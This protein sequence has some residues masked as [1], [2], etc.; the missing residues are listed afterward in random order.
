MKTSA[1]RLSAEL[2]LNKE[3]EQFFNAKRVELLE[4]I[5][6]Y[7]SISKAAKASK[8][9]YKTAWEWIEKMNSLSP[10]ALVQRISGGKGGGG[11]L[12]TAYAKELMRMYE[13]V[14][15]LHEK[16][17]LTLQGAFSQLEENIQ[18]ERFSFSRLNA[19]VKEISSDEKR[20]T[21]LLELMC[22]AEVS[23]QAPLTFVEVNALTAGSPIVL[24]I[25]SEAVSVSRSLPK[26]LSSRNK[27]K[28][29]VAEISMDGEDV[30][31]TLSLCGEQ[32]LT[33]RITI[34]SYKELRI[35][36]GDELMAMFKAYSPTLFCKVEKKLEELF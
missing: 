9:T 31:L 3:K 36:K 13:E 32:F 6:I 10:K 25:E 24:L 11:T 1:F 27:L 5:T 28:T 34:N 15:A 21:L 12:V 18:S 33:S 8:V 17:L 23:A 26:E 35:R 20:A 22:G 19:Q 29:T 2:H 14:Q 7:G 4:N 30:L 16:H